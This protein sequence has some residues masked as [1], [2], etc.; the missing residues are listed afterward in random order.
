MLFGGTLDA[1]R[2]FSFGLLKV[3]QGAQGERKTAQCIM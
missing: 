2:R 1:C 3:H